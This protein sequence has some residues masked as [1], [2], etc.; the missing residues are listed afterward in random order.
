MAYVNGRENDG[1][2]VDEDANSYLFVETLGKTEQIETIAIDCPRWDSV[3]KKHAHKQEI[4]RSN[5]CR[6]IL[7]ELIVVRLKLFDCTSNFWVFSNRCFRTK[8]NGAIE[9]AT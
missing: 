6:I 9:G 8:L 7:F 3:K 4:S 5:G 1:H 2:V